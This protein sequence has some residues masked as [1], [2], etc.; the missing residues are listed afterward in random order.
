MS[1]Q[2]RTLKNRIRSVENTKKITRAMEMVAAAK[3]R[4][5]QDMMQKARPYTE[6]LQSLLNRLKGG[7]HPFFEQREEK[8]CALLLMTSDTGLCGSYNTNLISLAAQFFEE[9]KTKPLLIGIGKFGI[10]AFK[11]MGVTTHTSITDLRAS[12]V[13]EVLSEL[14][15]LLEKLYLRFKTY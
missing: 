12:R 3:L 13:E 6:G 2:L 11:R 15:T 14:K 4:R 9:R 7:V 1:G 5:F 10:N 8:R